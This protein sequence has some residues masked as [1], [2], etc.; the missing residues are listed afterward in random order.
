MSC[1]EVILA[2]PTAIIIFSSGISTSLSIT[3]MVTI[4]A[5]LFT[6][7]LS[8]SLMK[9][10]RIFHPCEVLLGQVQNPPVGAGEEDV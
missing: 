8:G 1:L 2:P 4:P 3:V 5:A 6:E 9:R 7:L 10:S